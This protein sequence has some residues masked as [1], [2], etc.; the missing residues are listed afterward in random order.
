MKKEKLESS[1]PIKLEFPPY[2]AYIVHTDSLPQI[3]DAL[4]SK[5]QVNFPSIP[6]DEKKLYYLGNSDMSLDV[7]VGNYIFHHFKK[8]IGFFF[9][10][11]FLIRENRSEPPQYLFRLT[12]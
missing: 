3:F 2:E 5:F 4:W 12:R 11:N 7:D 6:E 8:M 1:L 9:E 10:S